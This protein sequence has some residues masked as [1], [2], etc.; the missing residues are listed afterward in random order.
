MIKINITSKDTDQVT[1]IVVVDENFRVL[2]LKRSDYVQKY[3]G[4]W[5]LPGGHVQYGESLLEG[6]KR[7]VKEE[8]GLNIRDVK[9]YKKVNN[10]HFYH[11]N[12][13]SQAIKTSHEHTGFRF[14]KKTNLDSSEK[15]QRVAIEIL[16]KFYDQS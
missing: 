12:Y 7:E 3:A 4:E 8:T 2:L 9:F 11:T 16:E 5:D 13:D 6:L 1:K 15:F 10:L 14:F